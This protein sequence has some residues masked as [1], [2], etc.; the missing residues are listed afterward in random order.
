MNTKKSDET[1]IEA[2]ETSEPQEAPEQAPPGS[3]RALEGDTYLSIALRYVDESKARDFALQMIDANGGA[4]VR[5]NSLVILP[6]TK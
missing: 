3:I 4:P 1:P 6:A 5:L 2:V